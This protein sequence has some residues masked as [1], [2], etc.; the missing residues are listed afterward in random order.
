MSDRAFRSLLQLRNSAS[1]ARVLNLHKVWRDNPE[2]PPPGARL[3]EHPLLDKSLIIKHR[4]RRDETDLFTGRRNAATKIILPIDYSD[5]K[6]G[7]HSIF[8]G[9]TSYVRCLEQ[10]FG[11]GFERTAD[12]D[13]LAILDALPSLDPFLLREHL[14]RHGRAPD[15]RYFEI[16]EADMSRMFG[17]ARSEIS[18]LVGLSFGD[19]I[20]SAAQ[21]SRLVH[22]ILSDPNDPDMEP[23]R[24]TLRLQK[25]EWGEGMFCWKGF[26]YYKWSL[27]E[28]ANHVGAV[29]DHMGKLRPTGAV[30]EEAAVNLAR[31]RVVLR[32]GVQRACAVTSETLRVY[33]DAYAKLVR[34]GAPTAFR[35]FLLDAPSMFTTL[36]ERLG[37]ISHVVSFWRYRFP[38]GA[39]T[40]VSVEELLDVF[41]EFE[42]SLNFPDDAAAASEAEAA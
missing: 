26:L 1:T 30:D 14:R 40:R 13:T 22:K 10:A 8:V 41:M 27:H 15:S 5:L 19:S 16:A 35:E 18:Q 17:F 36:G 6:L 28:I 2:P 3:F 7:G 32:R 42:S 12:F 4:L 23:L 29:L 25:E 21:V 11:S 39:Q 24:H 37:A 34:E 20:P 38:P 33:D 31:S 9:Q